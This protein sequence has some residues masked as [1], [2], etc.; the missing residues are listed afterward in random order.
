MT[1]SGA[2]Y[3]PALQDPSPDLTGSQILEMLQQSK[4]KVLV[5]DWSLQQIDTS[6]D[7]ILKDFVFIEE[8][9]GVAQSLQAIS[10]RKVP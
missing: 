9:M 6:I 2:V 5:V 8:K 4:V 10:P 3:N 1:G 7:T